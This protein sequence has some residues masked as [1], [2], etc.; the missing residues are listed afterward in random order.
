ME[1]LMQAN[2]ENITVYRLSA[3]LLKTRFD[4]LKSAIAERA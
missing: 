4:L 3:E 1:R 2:A